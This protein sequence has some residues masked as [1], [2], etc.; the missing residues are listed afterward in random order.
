MKTDCAANIEWMRSS[1]VEILTLVMWYMCAPHDP[2]HRQCLSAGRCAKVRSA[3]ARLW[4]WTLTPGAFW[5]CKAV[6]LKSAF[7]SNRAYASIATDRRSNRSFCCGIGFRFTP[8]VVVDTDQCRR[9]AKSGVH[10]TIPTSI[11]ADTAAHRL[12][13]HAA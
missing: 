13:N 12:N 4:Q 5:R 1:F 6:W 3:G 11:T 9:A 10:R 8:A 7:L 2:R